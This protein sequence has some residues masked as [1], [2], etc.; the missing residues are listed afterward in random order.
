MTDIINRPP[1]EPVPGTPLFFDKTDDQNDDTEFRIGLVMAGAISAGAYT[2]GVMDFIIEAIQKWDD[3]KQ[4]QNTD[5]SA[6]PEGGHV[7]THDIRFDALAGASAGGMCAGIFASALRNYQYGTNSLSPD[8][9]AKSLF[10]QAW[11]QKL[12]IG[13]MLTN[14]DTH[15]DGKKL[16]LKPASFLNVKGDYDP[17]GA[18]SLEGIRDFGIDVK[19]SGNWPTWLKDPLPIIL[20][21]SNLNGVPYSLNFNTSDRTAQHAMSKHADH[22]V[23]SLSAKGDVHHHATGLDFNANGGVDTWEGLGESL[24]ATGAFPLAFPPRNI[25]DRTGNWYDTQRFPLVQ[26]DRSI[27][28]IQGPPNWPDGFD[29]DSYKLWCVDGG[30]LNNEPMELARLAIA[31]KTGRNT[32]CPKKATR[33]ILMVDPFPGAPADPKKLSMNSSFLESI[34]QIISSLTQTARMKIDEL[35]L[36]H[37]S[38]S[39]SRFAIIPKK[40]VRG[41][42]GEMKDSERPLA[43]GSLGAFGGMLEIEWR[44]HDYLLG[45]L[46]AQKFLKDW[47]TVDADHEVMQ[48][49]KDH[50]QYTDANKNKIRLIP[51]VDGMDHITAAANLP[52]GVTDLPP[53]KKWGKSD[54]DETVKA[55]MKRINNV[56]KALRKGKEREEY[57]NPPKPEP[58]PEKA[59]KRGFFGRAWSGIK[60]GLGWVGGKVGTG[61]LRAYL[62]PG[63]VAGKTKLKSTLRSALKSNLA[64]YDLYEDD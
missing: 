39:V 1:P 14:K 12:N 62:F 17:N 53:P 25:K 58:T 36:F 13:A 22:V 11:V 44:H 52:E 9:S 46:N 31:D 4:A 51:L 61:L 45:R 37:N 35:V 8:Q 42:N 60:K 54:I 26:T 15:P 18:N 63:L 10:Y 56:L 3:R 47:F 34:G 59:K 27:D 48:N 33:M 49:H 57:H 50:A 28:W 30:M 64:D 38:D 23:Y 41:A 40:Y 16:T 43:S 6:V 32:R 7:P 19:S 2:A 5:P 29:K 24:L 21:V 55:V 20:T